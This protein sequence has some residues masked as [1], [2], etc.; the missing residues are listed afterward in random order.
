MFMSIL[1]SL[2]VACGEKSSETTGEVDLDNGESIYHSSCLAC[3]PN[4]GYDVEA[5]A[6]DFSDEE[7]ESIIKDG[8]GGMPA[9]SSLSDADVRD[10]VAYI[11]A[12]FG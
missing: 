1:L 5:V 6:V 2:F 9:Q 8:V 12:T 7:L 11:R 4:N 3:H 10:V